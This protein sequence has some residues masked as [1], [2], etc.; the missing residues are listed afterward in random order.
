MNRVKQFFA[1]VV[2][3]KKHTPLQ[4]GLVTLNRRFK[5]VLQTQVVDMK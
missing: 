3:S 4:R 1:F 5:K 2:R